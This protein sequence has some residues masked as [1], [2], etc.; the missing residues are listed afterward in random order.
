MDD[1][2]TCHLATQIVHIYKGSWL[3]G[4][5]TLMAQFTFVMP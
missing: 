2:Q 3:L 5:R 4:L 1:L